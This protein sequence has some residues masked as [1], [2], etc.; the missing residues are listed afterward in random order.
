MPQQSNTIPEEAQRRAQE[1]VSQWRISPELIAELIGHRAALTFPQG[2]AI[3][4]QGSAADVG[5]FV[6]S[7]LVKVCFVLMDGTRVIVRVAGAGDFIGVVDVALPPQTT[8]QPRRPV[9]HHPPR[10][11]CVVC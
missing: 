5:Y 7:G 4:I 8:R 2:K 9:R 3:F 1:L 10:S 6:L 11:H